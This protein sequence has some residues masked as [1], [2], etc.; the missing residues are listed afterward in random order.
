MS[1]SAKTVSNVTAPPG[2]GCD[3]IGVAVEG[4]AATGSIV[5]AAAG[6]S[7]LGRGTGIVKSA[8]DVSPAFIM[9]AVA[10]VGI[11]SSS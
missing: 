8:C 9:G 3:A 2:A 6:L 4:A 1:T 5:V 10:W 7:G 11:S